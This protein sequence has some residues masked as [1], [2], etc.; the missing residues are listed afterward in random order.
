MGLSFSLFNVAQLHQLLGKAEELVMNKAVQEGTN[1]LTNTH[2]MNAVVDQL[3]VWGD[4]ELTWTWLPPTLAQLAEAEDGRAI[5]ELCELALH[6]AVR[7]LL[8]H[9]ELPN[10]RG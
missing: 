8:Q 10:V 7:S 3:V 9:D 4:S 2:A 5:R 6:A 1:W